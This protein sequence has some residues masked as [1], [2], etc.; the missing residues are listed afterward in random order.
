MN[1]FAL[2]NIKGDPNSVW[3]YTGFEN[4]DTLIA[5]VFECLELQA[6]KMHFWQGRD[7]YNDGTL[8]YQN[9]NINEPGRKIKLLLLE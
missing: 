6:S 5:A 8:K 1:Y 2:E 3:F 7:K 4:Y 9:K